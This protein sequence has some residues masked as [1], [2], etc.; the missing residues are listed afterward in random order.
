MLRLRQQT[1]LHRVERRRVSE[2]AMQE[3]LRKT[4][5]RISVPQEKKSPKSP[6]F[7]TEELEFWSQGSDDHQRVQG[8][9]LARIRR[10][11]HENLEDRLEPHERCFRSYIRQDEKDDERHRDGSTSQNDRRSL[12]NRRSLVQSRLIHSIFPLCMFT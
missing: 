6:G 3:L 10:G 11:H 1:S 5:R 9:R 8:G 2:P 12:R 4:S 7:R